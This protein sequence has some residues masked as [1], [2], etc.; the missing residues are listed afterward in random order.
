MIVLSP[1]LFHKQQRLSWWRAGL[2]RQIQGRPDE[3]L[4]AAVHRELGGGEG[5]GRVRGRPRFPPGEFRLVRFARARVLL[6][7]R[8]GRRRLP[9]LVDAGRFRGQQGSGGVGPV[10]LCDDAEELHPGRRDA[11][12]W[13]TRD[14]KPT[15]SQKSLLFV[16][17]SCYLK[18]KNSLQSSLDFYRTDFDHKDYHEM[19]HYLPTAAYWF[20]DDSYDSSIRLQGYAHFSCKEARIGA[21]LENWQHFRHTRGLLHKC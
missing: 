16:I 2:V 14:R 13:G 12:V 20:E 18:K 11:Q 8:S 15:R 1:G 7:L 4:L 19:P 9:A 6:R 21:R 3:E 10:A 17:N 5:R